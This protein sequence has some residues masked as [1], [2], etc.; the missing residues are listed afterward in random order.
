MFYLYFAFI[1]VVIYFSLCYR[2]DATLKE[3]ASLVKEVHPEARKKGTRFDF[4]LV[5]PEARGPSYRRRDIGTVVSGVPGDDDKK[6][7]GDSRLM[8]GDY[9]DIAIIYPE[10]REREPF[11]KM[12]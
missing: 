7:L 10:R 5:F 9:M 1:C 11:R 6:T 4:A 8:I 2:K 3:I 12:Y